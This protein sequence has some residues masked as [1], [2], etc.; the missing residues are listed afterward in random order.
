M[1][2]MK[3]LMRMPLVINWRIGMLFLLFFTGSFTSF[4]QTSPVPKFI[5]ADSATGTFLS[6]ITVYVFNKI[7]NKVISTTITTD[8][9][10]CFLKDEWLAD[11]NNII[12]FNAVNFKE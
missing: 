1:M 12:V 7:E 2:P 4:A 3:K 11:T 10:H 8:S 6:K 9:G 5:V